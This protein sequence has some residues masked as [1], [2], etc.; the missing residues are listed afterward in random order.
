VAGRRS[1]VIAPPRQHKIVSLATEPSRRANIAESRSEVSVATSEI[2]SIAEQTSLIGES[3]DFEPEQ[4]LSILLTKQKEKSTI[5]LA[6]SHGEIKRQKTDLEKT[7]AENVL[8]HEV[9]LVGCGMKFEAR[10]IKEAVQAFIAATNKVEQHRFGDE[11]AKQN[12]SVKS[13]LKVLPPITAKD[14]FESDLKVLPMPPAAPPPKNPVPTRKA[15]SKKESNDAADK[16]HEQ[17]DERAPEEVIRTERF[18]IASGLLVKNSLVKSK[19]KKEML[20]PA[21]PKP[22]PPQDANSGPKGS[23]IGAKIRG[24]IQIRRNQA[25]EIVKKNSE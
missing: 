4:N 8:L 13:K 1:S 7:R 14:E 25:K 9:L 22:R 2:T 6:R 21:L 19:S 17:T 20:P 16:S 12:S 24:V 5:L 15:V 23:N 18:R 11:T 3:G 10:D